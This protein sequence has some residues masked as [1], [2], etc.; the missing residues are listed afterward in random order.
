MR[1][2]VLIATLSPL[3]F[4]TASCGLSPTGDSAAAQAQAANAAEPFSISVAGQ[5]DQPW[6]IAFIPG[7][8]Y[9]LVSEMKGRLKLWEEGGQVRDVVGAPLVDYGG[10]GGFGDVVLAP[11]YATTGNVYLSWAESG[12]GD[13]RG[14][15]VGKG[16]LQLEGQPR[17]NDLKVIWRQEPKTTGR[18]HYSHRI[19]FSPD[20]KYLF[21]A[22]G[23]RQKMTPA[24]Q[25]DGNLGKIVRLLPDGTPAPGN[26]FADKGGVNAQI[27]SLGHRNILGLKFDQQGQL[28]DL[29]HGPAG[30]DELNRVEPGK[31]YG[32]PVVSN[33]DHYDGKKIP[34]HPTRPDFATPG[35]SWNPV[36]APGDFIFYSGNGFPTWKG[37]ALIAA[38]SPAGLVRVEMDGNTARE[39][40][41]YP[42]A[43]RIRD[44]DQSE[45]GTLW[46]LEDG[47]PPG[48]GRLLKL[49]P[50]KN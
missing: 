9:A 1:K 32:W 44:I 26:P 21:I 2:S 11:D 17:I 31:N 48:A 33:G 50:A 35:I 25:M 19:A 23:D 10:Q 6:A 45:D 24:Q 34:R 27:W 42:M 5:F 4:A 40:A 7:T 43:Q 28:W 18:G 13:T 29:E 8:R 12:E 37:Q 47:P 39:L 36:I 16:K 38:M 14:A 49:T 20:G 30:G 46:L 22:S 15:V 3:I 41:R